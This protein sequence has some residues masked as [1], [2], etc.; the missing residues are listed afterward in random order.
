M[1]ALRHLSTEKERSL[2][3]AQLP[4]TFY[5]QWPRDLESISV[6]V[7]HVFRGDAVQD[8]MNSSL[9]EWVS[10]WKVSQSCP[11]LC[12]P[13]DYTVHGILL[14][15]ILECVAFPFSRGS[16]QLRDQTQVSCIAGRFCTSWAT[17]EAQACWKF[18]WILPGQRLQCVHKNSVTSI[19]SVS[20]QPYG[21]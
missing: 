5:F 13:M 7:A 20:M 9:L 11:T 16:S 1:Q 10:E 12:N 19:V 2:V 3:C 4:Y 6:F 15:R 17:R 18:N 14:A 8:M 21:L